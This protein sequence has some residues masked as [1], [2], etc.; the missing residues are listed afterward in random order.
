MLR[1]ERADSVPDAKTA[2]KEADWLLDG[3]WL[4]QALIRY[5]I[6]RQLQS[7]IHAIQTT[8]LE[9]A[10]QAKMK[11]VKALRTRPM[12]I[13]TATANSQH[14]E[15]GTGVLKACLGPRMKYSCCLY[16][17]GKETLGHAEVE[18]LE[19]YIEK[20]ELTDG[21]KIL[22]LGCEIFTR[23]CNGQW[24]TRPTQLRLGIWSTLL[25]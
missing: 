19:T 6:R 1:V 8:S 22:D 24:L 21:M 13:E 4:P 25:C 18:M 12:A 7:R 17:T 5:G 16:P 2:E 3:G 10:Y 9:E 23:S 15:V 14:Y 20:A 11:F